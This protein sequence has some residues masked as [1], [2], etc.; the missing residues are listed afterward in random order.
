VNSGA[1]KPMVLVLPDA[2]REAFELAT[3]DSAA[4]ALRTLAL[5]AS[6][7][8]GWLRRARLTVAVLTPAA[9]ATSSMVA[10]PWLS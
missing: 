3:Y 5:V 9:R 8:Y 1:S 6:D 10:L 2:S 4:A 7:T